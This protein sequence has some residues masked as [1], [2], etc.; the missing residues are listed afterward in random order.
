M[1]D[2][3]IHVWASNVSMTRAAFLMAVIC[4]GASLSA[5]TTA[6]APTAQPDSFQAFEVA[7][8]R[9]NR[10]SPQGRFFRQQPGG[11]FEVTNMPLRD[12]IQ[13]AYQVR[14]FQ[15][16]GGPDWI[17]TTSFD[18]V[19]KAPGEVP[20]VAPGQT[21]PYMLMMRALL[22]E[23]FKLVVRDETREM[24]IYALALA[25]SDG[26]VGPQLS[27]STTDCAALMKAAQGGAPPAPTD[28]VNC[29]LRIGPGRLDMGAF[30][31]SEMANALGMLLQRTVVNRTG[32]TANFDASMKFAPEQLPG[33]PLPPPGAPG[34]PPIDPDAPSIFTALQEQLGL[35][36]DSTRGPVRLVVVERAEMPTED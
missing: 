3:Q 33:M 17:G 12:L 24:P 1:P 30:G 21:S 5:Q 9:V 14:N 26:K 19:A 27:V 22:A 15:V 36:L 28:R 10:S 6:T 11:R 18:I 13:F 7:S 4:A 23:R 32:L 35:K 16:E 2:N 25:R 31:L 29:G 20:P 8:V 34:A